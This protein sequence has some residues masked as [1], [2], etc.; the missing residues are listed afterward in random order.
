MIPVSA[1][2][3]S[4]VVCCF[5]VVVA[6][7]VSADHHL[8]T[9]FAAAFLNSATQHTLALPYA[10]NSVDFQVGMVALRDGICETE[11]VDISIRCPRLR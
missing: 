9:G 7:I 3:R 2:S 6:L 5:Q 8:L 1:G 4:S 10:L 11:D